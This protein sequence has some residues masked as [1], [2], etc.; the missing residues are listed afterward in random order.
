MASE[1]HKQT[2]SV[3]G[4]TIRITVPAGVRNGQEIKLKGHGGPGVNNGPKGD[5]YITFVIAED[6]RF[7]R[8]GD[9]LYMNMEIDLETAVLGGEVTVET[10]T[11]KVKLKVA[12][13]TQNGTQVRLKNKGF[14]KYKKEGSFGDLI[15]AFHVKIPTHLTPEQ[16]SEF[17]KW[18]EL[19]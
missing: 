14:P 8:V 17:K 15:I 4:K 1:T 6:P 12:E 7:K 10:L 18:V 5:L 13:G 16:K 2:L 3:N 19:K 9:H 11:G